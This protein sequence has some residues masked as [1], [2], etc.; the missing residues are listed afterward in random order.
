MV[1][2][3]SH[4]LEKMFSPEDL[5][6]QPNVSP[7]TLRQVAGAICHCP[8]TQR[9]RAE[10]HYS[11]KDG[12][13]TM[14]IVLCGRL[15]VWRYKMINHADGCLM[16][17]VHGLLNPARCVWRLF[18]QPPSAAIYLQGAPAGRTEVG[19]KNLWESLRKLVAAGCQK[20]EGLDV[21]WRYVQEL[22]Y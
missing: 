16:G 19:S 9:T 3:M 1:G 4:T 10:M 8:S 18:R 17:T 15:R 6:V 22:P 14:N 13:L 20:G 7:C 2:T 21:W 11:A 5:P 12:L